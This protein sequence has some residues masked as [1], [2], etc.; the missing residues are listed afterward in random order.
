M[1]ES[2]TND[3]EVTFDLSSGN[4]WGRAV[5]AQREGPEPGK[6]FEVAG[7]LTP[8]PKVADT[9][10]VSDGSL[11]KFDRVEAMG[12]PRDGFFATLTALENVGAK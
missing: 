7:C 3:L 5:Y 1:P 6:P 2:L 8:L 11:W 9:L 12:N 4:K 10:R